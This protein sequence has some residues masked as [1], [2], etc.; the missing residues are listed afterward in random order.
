MS[1]KGI[2]QSFDSD[3]PIGIVMDVLCFAA[4]AAEQCAALFRQ[5]QT[6]TTPVVTAQARRPLEARRV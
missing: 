6:E 1:I 3:N 5:V 4:F 2:V